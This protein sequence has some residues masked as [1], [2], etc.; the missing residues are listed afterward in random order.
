MIGMEG[1]RECL[2]GREEK[3]E[4]RAAAP[5]P[6]IESRDFEAETVET[7]GGT[8]FDGSDVGGDGGVGVSETVD[9]ADFAGGV[10]IVGEDAVVVVGE[11]SDIG[12]RGLI[13][14]GLRGAGIRNR[15]R[16]ITASA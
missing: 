9:D 8:E 3:F 6:V 1:P 14:P 11:F 16:S 15:C 5:E 13:S 7:P 12:E 10:A 2:G 4:E